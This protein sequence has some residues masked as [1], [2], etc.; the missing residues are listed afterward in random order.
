[1]D[2]LRHDRLAELLRRA[3][4]AD[5]IAEPLIRTLKDS[6]LWVLPLAT[7]AEFVEQLRE[8]KRGYNEPLLIERLLLRTPHRAR[9]D[10]APA[11]RGLDAGQSCVSVR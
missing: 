2:V 9:T 1:M 8:F 11:S 5:G 3:G 7:V 4:H 6:R 10:V